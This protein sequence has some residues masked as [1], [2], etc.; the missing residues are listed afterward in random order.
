MA[1]DRLARILALKRKGSSGGTV[2]DVARQRITAHEGNADIHV[3]A[4]DKAKWNAVNYSNPNL[5][6]NSDFRINQRGQDSYTVTGHTADCWFSQKLF[7]VT[8]LESGIR[9]EPV[10][11]VTTNSFGLY[12]QIPVSKAMYGNDFTLTTKVAATN[13]Y[14]YAV[15]YAYNSA[16]SVIKSSDKIKLQTGLN[17]VTINNL[18]DTTSYIRI[19]FTFN[20]GAQTSDILEVE[21][22]KLE[23]GSIATPFVPPDTATELTKC[24]RFYQIRS[25]NDI[26]AVDLRPS[27]ATIKDI[28]LREDGDYEYIAE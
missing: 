5:L 23:L 20:S 28:K 14:A 3:T 4:E 6:I 9:I 21:W 15:I 12:Q 16:D 22:T 7:T 11:A 27:M 10:E 17:S 1:K 18:P 19:Q 8:P 24:Q 13:D 25:T 2:D 26:A